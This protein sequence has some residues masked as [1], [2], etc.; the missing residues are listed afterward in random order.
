MGKTIRL[1][2]ST[3]EGY[4]IHGLVRDKSWKIE[5][6]DVSNDCAQLSLSLCSADFPDM[7]EE[8]P[9][10]FKITVN[11]ILRDG[12]LEFKTTA[13]N[14]SGDT[15]P[16]GFGVHT[17]FMVPFIA[18]GRRRDCSIIVPASSYWELEEP[19]IGSGRNVPTGRVLPVEGT[20]W[21]LRSPKPLDFQL[22]DV[23]TDL[24][25]ENGWTNVK[26]YDPTA[27]F[28]IVNSSDASFKHVCVFVRN[29]GAIAV[30]PYTCTTDAFNLESR[31]IKADI[32]VLEAGQEWSGTIKIVPHRG[33]I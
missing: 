11:W 17:W 23:L 12:G 9:Y 33:R 30:E 7:E 15:M 18:T 6:S 1:R 21:D 3:R 29:C 5:D 28:T 32:I 2:P 25:M 27:D 14:Q 16:M 31:G 22:D 19:G 20:K 4:A 24:R 10:R 8:F 26:I 13:I